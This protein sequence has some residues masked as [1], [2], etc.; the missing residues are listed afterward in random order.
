MSIEDILEYRNDIQAK[1]KLAYI[2]GMDWEDIAQELYLH[3]WLVRHKYDSTKSSRRT[4]I[5]RVVVNKIRDLARKSLAKKRN[6]YQT[7]SL[8]LLMESGFDVA[9]NPYV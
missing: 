5:A 4:F 9:Y 2:A 6:L 7:V 8:D 3:L 1:A